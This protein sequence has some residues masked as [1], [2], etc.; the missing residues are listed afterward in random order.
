MYVWWAG[1]CPNPVTVDHHHYF[2]EG[3][4]VDQK[5]T[6]TERERWEQ[7]PYLESVPCSALPLVII[8]LVPFKEVY[9]FW[10]RGS[11]EESEDINTPGPSKQPIPSRWSSCGRE[12]SKEAADCGSCSS[13]IH[14]GFSTVCTSEYSLWQNV[15][16]DAI[17]NGTRT[18]WPVGT[19]WYFDVN[20]S[21]ADFSV[22]MSTRHTYIHSPA[23]M[24][25]PQYWFCFL[26]LQIFVGR[27]CTYFF[28]MWCTSVWFGGPALVVSSFWQKMQGLCKSQILIQYI[29]LYF[30]ST[31]MW[32]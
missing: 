19:V 22:V 4:L 2:N 32:V 8:A 13:C 21:F 1:G 23:K 3:S 9:N 31:S 18:V 28:W 30:V 20:S 10:S 7:I 27:K 25:D 6:V 29:S 16:D 17:S 15:R 12:T 11:I 26:F 24:P 5:S 14:W